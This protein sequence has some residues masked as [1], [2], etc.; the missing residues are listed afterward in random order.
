MT[1]DDNPGSLV[2]VDLGEVGGQPVGLLVHEAEGTRVF[3]SSCWLVGADETVTCL[4]VRTPIQ[5]ACVVED[6][7]NIPRSVS[8]SSWM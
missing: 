8:V 5:A 2:A 6:Y 3:T 7:I 1:G 4:L